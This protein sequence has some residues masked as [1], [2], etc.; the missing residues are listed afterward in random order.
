[1]MVII[2]LAFLLITNIINP[3]DKYCNVGSD[4]IL[5]YTGLES[6]GPCDD[7][8]SGMQCVSLREAEEIRNR[9][10]LIGTISMCEPCATPQ[11]LYRCACGQNGCEKTTSCSADSDCKTQ[12]FTKGYAC[13]D[14]QCKRI[15][16]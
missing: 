11:I 6:C 16:T 12:I 4:C 2:V 10:N 8:S 3:L 9:R 14:N 13:I 1:M 7:S 15:G 5:A